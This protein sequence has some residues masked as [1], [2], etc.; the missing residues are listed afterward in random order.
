[1][2]LKIELS[3]AGIAKCLRQLEAYQNNLSTKVEK[4]C[5]ELAKIG[6]DAAY[7]ILNTDYRV[8]DD[9]VTYSRESATEYLVVAQGSQVAFIEFGVG[10][11][12][13]S[14]GYPSEKLPSEWQYNAMWSPWAHDTEDPD[15][16]FY[17][18]DDGELDNTKGTRP[19]GFMNNASETMRLRVSEIAKKVFA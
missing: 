7:S 13:A 5:L 9:I 14:G 4:F 16:W 18:D 1:M 15:R 11:V 19:V 6:I 10:V 17:Y 8:K 3:E 12:G 2:E